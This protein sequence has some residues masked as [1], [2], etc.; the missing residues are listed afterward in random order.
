MSLDVDV[1]MDA[2]MRTAVRGFPSPENTNT[3]VAADIF[4]SG[5]DHLTFFAHT[6]AEIDLLEAL[7]ND[8][9]IALAAARIEG[10]QPTL[11]V[12]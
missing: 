5:S 4:A 12:A 1:H 3:F 11:E 8:M 6:E 10:A 9:R 7:V 2:E